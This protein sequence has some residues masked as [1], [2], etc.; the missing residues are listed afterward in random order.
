MIIVTYSSDQDTT[1]SIG[2]DFETGVTTRTTDDKSNQDQYNMHDNVRCQ[3]HILPYIAT[4]ISTFLYIVGC[5][6]GMIPSMDDVSEEERDE[7]QGY[8]R[9][10]YIICSTCIFTSILLLVLNL[11]LLVKGKWIYLTAGRLYFD[12]HIVLII[13]MVS[14]PC[15]YLFL[16]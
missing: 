6:I 16:G 3:K 9:M 1:S 11:L 5:I 2:D 13:F 4:M 10:L 8:Y 15:I 12:L 7:N 14:L